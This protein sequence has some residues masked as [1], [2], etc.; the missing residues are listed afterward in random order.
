MRHCIHPALKTPAP[1][2]CLKAVRCK[3]FG[4]QLD[5]TVHPSLND[6]RD[7]TWALKTLATVKTRNPE[8]LL[9][10]HHWPR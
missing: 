6:V 9:A 8:K 2:G 3:R 1:E 4:V 7:W 10:L 5:T